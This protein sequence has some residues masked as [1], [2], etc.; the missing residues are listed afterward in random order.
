MIQCFLK[1]WGPHSKPGPS[2]TCFQVDNTLLIYLRPQ[3]EF[4]KLIGYF[5]ILQTTVSLSTPWKHTSE[6]R[7]QEEHLRLV[8]E[9]PKTSAI[10]EANDSY[11]QKSYCSFCLGSYIPSI[12][13]LALNPLILDFWDGTS[14]DYFF[15]NLFDYPNLDCASWRTRKW[16]IW[17]SIWICCVV[18]PLGYPFGT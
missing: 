4:Y 1:S 9:P 16:S 17:F 2:P 11:P 3:E 7:A 13:S 8:K 12:H 14:S 6:E 15:L 10:E 5:L 18:L